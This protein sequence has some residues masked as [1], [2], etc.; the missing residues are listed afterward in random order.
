VPEANNSL[1]AQAVAGDREALS[2]LLQ[3]HAP[4]LRRTLRVESRWLSPSDVDDVLQVT[5]LEAFLHIHRF[6]PAAPG[7]F[8]GWLL[9]IARNNVRDLKREATAAKRPALDKRIAWYAEQSSIALVEKLTGS[10]PTPSRAFAANEVQGILERALEKLPEDYR[11]V[12]QLY[13]L[14]GHSAA[15]V[16][17]QL[18]RSVGAI[19]MLRWR[20]HDR[21]REILG[22][23]SRF[24][25]RGA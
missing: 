5:F 24:F 15:R 9:S 11:R 20:A 14:E 10:G 13:D 1:I 18:E 8:S 4:E 21:L 16:A 12:V 23:E 25:S 22:S 6:D 7:S 3:A 19:Y 2:A 17:Q